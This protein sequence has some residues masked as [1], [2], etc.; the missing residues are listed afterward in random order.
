MELDSFNLKLIYAM[1]YGKMTYI[2]CLNINNN[3]KISYNSKNVK[4]AL[5]NNF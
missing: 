1:L 4:Q 5:K 3:L 2:F